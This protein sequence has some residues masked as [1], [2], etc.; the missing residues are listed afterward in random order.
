M[1]AAL[2]IILLCTL[3]MG[4]DKYTEKI[5]EPNNCNFINYYYYGDS[6]ITLGELSNDYITVAFDSSATESQ[7]RNFIA[8]E[9]IFDTTYHY[10]PSSYFVPLKFKEPKSCQEI[11]AVIATLQKNPMVAFVHY[12]MQ[13]DCSYNFMPILG[14]RCV[15]IYSNAFYV[16]VKNVNDLSDLNTMI[17]STRTELVHQ[18]SYMPQWF[19][20]RATKNSKG[21]ALRMANHFKESKLFEYAEPNLWKIPVE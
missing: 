17:K 15:M 13:T 11:T 7:I 16:K 19:T 1:K 4:C 12:T 8:V 5:I 10:T 9:K 14:S 2:Y 6:I 20:L 3:L 18:N 21:D